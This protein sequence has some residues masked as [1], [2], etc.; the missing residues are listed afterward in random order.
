VRLVPSTTGYE[1]VLTHDDRCLACMRPSQAEA[2]EEKRKYPLP[3]N[4]VEPVGG[5]LL[6]LYAPSPIAP[7]DVASRGKLVPKSPDVCNRIIRSWR[8]TWTRVVKRAV[9]QS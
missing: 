2:D 8:S 3:A 1:V 5:W 4:A 9:A 6:A 7:E